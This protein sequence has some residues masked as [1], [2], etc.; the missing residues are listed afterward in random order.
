[1][2]TDKKLPMVATKEL[3]DM[4]LETAFMTVAGL[5]KS[6]GLTQGDIG[7]CIGRTRQ[8]MSKVLGTSDYPFQLL[9]VLE[10]LGYDAEIVIRTKIKKQE[11]GS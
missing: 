9:K 1:M 3:G 6:L 8:T 10:C 2:E 5:A 4:K 11:D 7:D